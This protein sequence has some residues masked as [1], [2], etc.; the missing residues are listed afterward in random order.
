MYK[1]VFWMTLIVVSVG[2]T[3]C[4]WV[5]LDEG[6]DE[7][8]LVSADRVANCEKLGRAHVQ[9]AEQVGVI[10]RHDH[11]VEENL[12]DVARNQAVEMGGD[13]IVPETEPEEGRQTF[14][15]YR[16]RN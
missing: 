6:A 14:G 11:V 2:L 4:T 13:T 15:V 16:C 7:V 12:Q 3:G 8:L 9:V 5:Q 1:Q 10:R